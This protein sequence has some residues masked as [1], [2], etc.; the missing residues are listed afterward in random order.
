MSW[1]NLTLDTHFLISP[2]CP[3]NVDI[4]SMSTS[5]AISSI[6]TQLTMNN[7]HKS[8]IPRTSFLPTFQLPPPSPHPSPICTS[9]MHL[10]IPRQPIHALPSWHSTKRIIIP[11]SCLSAPEPRCHTLWRQCH[12]SGSRAIA[13]PH[14]RAFFLSKAVCSRS[15]DHKCA[16]G[17]ADGKC[18][19]L[20]CAGC[21]EP[22]DRSY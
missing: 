7:T 12:T 10:S 13:R 21:P 5:G 17:E 6:G 20:H 4:I 15:M 9:I 3:R 16:C 18:V 22:C 8:G 2:Q 14:P 11:A 1:V 19:M